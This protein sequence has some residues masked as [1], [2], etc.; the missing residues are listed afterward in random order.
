METGFM[1]HSEFKKFYKFV[2][3]FSREG[4]HRTIEKDMVVALLQMVL[5]DR[6]N[7]HLNDFCSFLS[8]SG[9][10]ATRITLDQWTSFLD[11]SVTV[12]DDC[13]GYEDDEN[14]AWPVLVDEYVA[15]KGKGKK[16]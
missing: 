3:Q 7:I 11:F 9:P 6:S 1:E 5:G 10:E 4:T 16:K 12:P 8:S 13:I 14:C 15:W 2:F